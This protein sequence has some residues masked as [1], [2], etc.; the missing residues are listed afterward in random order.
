MMSKLNALK[1]GAYARTTLLPY[2]NPQ[3]FEKLRVEIF[4]DLQPHGSLEKETVDN[5][6]DNRWQRRRQRERTAIDM[7]RHPVGQILE[8]SGARSWRE[9]AAVVRKKKAERDK[10]MEDL[11]KA[12]RRIAESVATWADEEAESDELTEYARQIR[13]RFDRC[14]EKVTRIETRRDEEDD[15]FAEHLPKG[16]ERQIGLENSLDAPFDKQRA[17]LLI[18]QEARILRDKLPRSQDGG[19]DSAVKQFDDGPKPVPR[20][21]VQ[22]SDEAEL[23]RDDDDGDPLSD[24]VAESPAPGSGEAAASGEP[25]RDED[26]TDDWGEPIKE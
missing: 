4:A 25:E 18:L 8:E 6:V 13:D 26:A 7:H 15:L 21:Q 3:D 2:E 5:I 22:P 12:W 16:L 19:G 24:F 1:S 17:R 9:A 23:D 20:D 14:L 11:P 10:L